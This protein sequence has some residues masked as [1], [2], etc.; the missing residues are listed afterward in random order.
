MKIYLLDKN[1]EMVDAWNRYFNYID[2]EVVNDDFAHFMDNHPEVDG[3][4]SPSNSFGLMDGG[5]DKAIIDY[6]GK[7]LE[8]DV[9]DKIIY[10]WYGEQ[11]V[12]TSMAVYFT[13][14]AT[15]NDPMKF[16][17]HTP[18][19]RVPSVITDY[20]VIY[21]CMRNCI[22]NAKHHGLNNIVIPAFGGC[23]GEVPYNII[24][25]MM[26]LGYQQLKNIPK[27][28]NWSYAHWVNDKVNDIE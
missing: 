24:A 7:D 1:K 2:V 13:G 8:K 18:T 26:H 14:K 9:Q 6:Y 27:T 20:N 5:Y 12:G 16:L 17:I 4:V 15:G 10:E 25:K 22:I 3:I 19:M 23:C 21:Q 28:I 11:P